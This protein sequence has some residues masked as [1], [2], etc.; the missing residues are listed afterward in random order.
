M[1]DTLPEKVKFS[2]DQNSEN[3]QSRN[4]RNVD[5]PHNGY[6]SE[7]GDQNWSIFVE[8]EVLKVGVLE[9]EIAMQRE[10]HSERVEL[11]A[12]QTFPDSNSG[13][14]LS[15]SKQISPRSRRRRLKEVSSTP[16]GRRGIML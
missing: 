16:S 13:R 4:A 2:R 15:N 11:W 1:W 8:Q 14:N 12:R 3:A 10:F 9:V 6:K 5:G 7:R